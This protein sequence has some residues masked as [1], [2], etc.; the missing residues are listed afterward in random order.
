MEILDLLKSNIPV[1]EEKA[2][3]QDTLARKLCVTPAIAK[4]MVR[5]AREKGLMICSGTSGYWIANDEDEFKHFIYARYKYAYSIFRGLKPFK[6]ILDEVKGQ[7]S[8]SDVF[9]DE[10]EE[11]KDDEQEQ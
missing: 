6:H 8:L 2:I 7:L 3:H 5:S 1:G 10:S 9:N 4:E 11:V